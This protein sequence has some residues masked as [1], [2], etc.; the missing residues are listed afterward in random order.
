MNTKIF[1]L[2]ADAIMQAYLAIYKKLVLNIQFCKLDSFK[3]VNGVLNY[4][5]NQENGQVLTIL[6]PQNLNLKT[7]C[8][9]FTPLIN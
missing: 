6:R 2:F 5:K 3:S 1:D 7:W 4:L 9:P 8:Q